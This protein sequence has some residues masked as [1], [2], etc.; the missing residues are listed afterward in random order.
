MSKHVGFKSQEE[1]VK[2]FKS[3]SPTRQHSLT[4]PSQHSSAHE[5]SVNQSAL[6]LILSRYDCRQ[7][8]FNIVCCN[9]SNSGG[10]GD[11]CEHPD[12]AAPCWIFSSEVPSRGVVCASPSLPFPSLPFPLQLNT[13]LEWNRLIKL[14]HSGRQPSGNQLRSCGC[15]TCHPFSN[16][17]PK[18]N[19]SALWDTAW[20]AAEDG[21][22]ELQTHSAGYFPPFPLHASLNL[23]IPIFWLP[24]HLFFHPARCW[25]LKPSPAW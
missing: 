1:R 4:N 23:L 3:I 22:S 17:W 19:P 13:S 7:K 9:V 5:E 2:L 6:R 10:S 12:K 18:N 21:L 16:A 25:G 8:P 24:S 11:G 14:H 20:A 15:M